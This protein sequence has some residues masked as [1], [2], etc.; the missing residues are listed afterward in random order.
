MSSYVDPGAARSSGEFVALLRLRREVAGLSYRQLE[1][2]A[3]Q[4]GGCL[5]PST[6]ATMLRR[7]TLPS[8]ELVVAY[9]RAC[10]GDADEVAAWVAVRTRLATTVEAPVE[11]RGGV[12][13]FPV[14]PRQLPPCG[15]ALVGRRDRLAEVDA[16]TGGAESP[17]VVVTGAPGV[18]KTALAVHWA[19]RVRDRF[20]DGQLYVEL[21]A[22]RPLAD[23]LGELLAAVGVP[24]GS[25]PADDRQAA[26]LFRSVVADRRVL[27]LVD[28]VVTA[29]QVRLLRPGGSDSCMVVT[30][31]DRLVGLAVYD[32]ARVVE[33]PPLERGHAVRVLAQAAGERLVSAELTAAGRLAELCDRL[34]LALRIAATALDPSA[35]TP[36]ADLVV[37][38]RAF[39]R[40]AALEV[41]GDPE[42]GLDAVFGRSWEALDEVSRGLLRALAALPPGG[43]TAVAAA[44]ALETTVALARTALGRLVNAHLVVR[45]GDDRYAVPGLL[46]EYAGSVLPAEEP[47]VA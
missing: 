19:H 20:P 26:A 28:G 1:R 32:G 8:R 25:V 6:V 38:M 15:V 27:L 47:A 2:R 31:R 16:A 14:P 24:A 33:T 12:P 41:H 7:S 4:D 37:R 34:P 17:L 23:V 40:L 10:G 30:S 9:V 42:V 39:G 3:R 29:E 18:G 35:T 45:L 46:R 11:R 44:A 5:P 36:I 43:V 22:S 13:S 21:G